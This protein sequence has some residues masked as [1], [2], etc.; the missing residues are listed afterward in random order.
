M[1]RTYIL[2]EDQT[3]KEID[4]RIAS[5]WN[6][7]WSVKEIMKNKVVILSGRRHVF[8]TCILP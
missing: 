7:Y 1:P 8:N 3:S 6:K 5:G 2:F 4:K